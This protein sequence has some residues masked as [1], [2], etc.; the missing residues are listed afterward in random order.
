MIS[1]ETVWRSRWPCIMPENRARFVFS[2]S[3]SAF[4]W[5]VSRRLAIIWLMLSL[6]SATSPWASTVICAREVA[7]R[8]RGRDVG[9]R[10]HLRR[11]VAG[12]LVHVVGQVPPRAGDAL[13]LGLA[14]EA[15]LGADLAGHARDLGGERRELVDHRVDRVLE[16]EDLAAASTVIFCDRSPWATAVVTWAML[17]TWLGEVVGQRVDVVG[18]VV[19]GAATRP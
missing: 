12:E 15:A 13:D 17:R 4:C 16:L 6:S 18:E 2:Q 5:V 8:H 9:D 10:A 14:A 1:R 19:P 7:L 11:Q 3:C